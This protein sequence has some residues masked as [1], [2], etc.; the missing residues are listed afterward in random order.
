[1]NMISVKPLLKFAGSYLYIYIFFCL[2]QWNCIFFYSNEFHWS[3]GPCFP[4]NMQ[5]QE[6][7]YDVFSYQI[8]FLVEA[9]TNNS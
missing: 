6:F 2:T 3:L 7:F 5:F 4:G 8:Y 1:M 9:L